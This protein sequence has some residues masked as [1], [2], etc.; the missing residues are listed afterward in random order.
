MTTKFNPFARFDISRFPKLLD[1]NTMY[2][3]IPIS[4]DSSTETRESMDAIMN[5]DR[6]PNF[7]SRGNPRL[8]IIVTAIASAGFFAAILVL[9]ASVSGPAANID[10]S[11]TR[12]MVSPC[13]NTAEEAR[14]RGCHFDIISFCWLPD[15]CYDAKL[16]ENFDNITTWE[17]FLDSNGTQPISHDQAMTGDYTG[18]FV[19]WEYHVRHCT[20]MWEKMHRAILGRGKSAIDGYIGPLGHTQHCSQMLLTVDDWKE[21]NTIILVKFPDCGIA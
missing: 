4:E 12:I 17:W 10:T 15:A 21:L 9:A 5:S 2:D 20:A 18:L 1:A 13:G 3:S 11:D 19:N 6:R 14:A 7:Q 16:S 8:A